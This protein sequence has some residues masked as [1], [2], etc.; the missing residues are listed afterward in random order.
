MRT[1][2]IPA[3]AFL[4]ECQVR[5]VRAAPLQH[6]FRYGTYQWL[7]DV[8]DRDVRDRGSHSVLLTAGAGLARACG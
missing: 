5:H 1:G 6:S 3:P 7:V 8:D 4:Y 2:V